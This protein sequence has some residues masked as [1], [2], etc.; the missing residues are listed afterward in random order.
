MLLVARRERGRWRDYCAEQLASIF[1]RQQK[2]QEQ[3][4]ANDS[5]AT[6][7]GFSPSAPPGAPL[8]SSTASDSLARPSRTWIGR[9][10]CGGT[11]A[12]EFLW[13]TFAVEFLPNLLQNRIDVW[14]K[15]RESSSDQGSVLSNQRSSPGSSPSKL[16]GAL[17]KSSELVASVAH[18]NRP[19]LYHSAYLC[20]ALDHRTRPSYQCVYRCA[21]A[22]LTKISWN[23]KYRDVGIM[24][25]ANYG[26]EQVRQTK[27]TNIIVQYT[28][29]NAYWD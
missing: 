25:S 17:R 7:H 2:G 19:L 23:Y 11:F 8:L 12:V 15:A 5:F 10:P 18:S 13:A 21:S 14:T 6:T 9:R 28:Y 24:T 1:R 26:F 27:N 16:P 4:T 29:A 22:I 3:T 20:S